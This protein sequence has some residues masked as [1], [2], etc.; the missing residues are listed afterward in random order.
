[1][2]EIQRVVR[3]AKDDA[4]GVAALLTGLTWPEVGTT[5]GAIEV[6]ARCVVRVGGTELLRSALRCD[7]LTA[8]RPGLAVALLET[9]GVVAR[10]DCGQNAARLRAQSDEVCEAALA[11]AETCGPRLARAALGTAGA[12]IGPRVDPSHLDRLC[13]LASSKYHTQKYLVMNHHHMLSSHSSSS[14][15]IIAAASDDEAQRTRAAAL[16]AIVEACAWLDESTTSFSTTM[17]T[18]MLPAPRRWLDVGKDKAVEMALRTGDWPFIDDDIY[19]GLWCRPAGPLKPCSLVDMRTQ[20]GGGLRLDLDEAGSLTAAL[21]SDDAGE[22]WIV[23]SPP[24]VKPRTWIHV[25]V[26]LR[27]LTDDEEKLHL[28]SSRSNDL[29][30]APDAP[31]PDDKTKQ[32]RPPLQ[33]RTSRTQVFFAATVKQQPQPPSRKKQRRVLELEVDGRIVATE[34]VDGIK[35]SASLR[36]ASL[37]GHFDGR[38]AGVV[39]LTQVPTAECRFSLAARCCL[40]DSDAPS[41]AADAKCARSAPYN[42]EPLDPRTPEGQDAVFACAASCLRR[43]GDAVG[44]FVFE[45]GLHKEFVSVPGE[46]AIADRGGPALLL[47]FY[48]HLCAPQAKVDLDDASRPSDSATTGEEEPLVDSVPLSPRR[49]RM[50]RWPHLRIGPR[51]ALVAAC[52]RH[53]DFCSEFFDIGGVDI[54]ERCLAVR[55]VPSVGD[56]DAA[57]IAMSLRTI[58]DAGR[59]RH[60]A[61]CVAVLRKIAFQ[62]DL[63]DDAAITDATHLW[64]QQNPRLFD[65]ALGLGV[66]LARLADL[67][68]NH[69]DFTTASSHP[70]PLVDDDDDDD[71][72]SPSGDDLVLDE[73]QDDDDSDSDDDDSDSDD[74]DDDDTSEEEEEEEDILD[75]ENG[76]KTKKAV[77]L[78][79]ADLEEEDSED[80]DDTEA[81]QRERAHKLALLPLEL[82]TTMNRRRKKEEWLRLRRARL[83]ALGDITRRL[84]ASETGTTRFRDD[85]IRFVTTH[86][87]DEAAASVVGAAIAAA[88]NDD[89]LAPFLAESIVRSRLDRGGAKSVVAVAKLWKTTKRHR[90]FADAMR[91][92][93]APITDEAYDGFLD[94]CRDEDPLLAF[95]TTA[96][97]LAA[98][99]L[100]AASARRFCDF[101]LATTPKSNVVES[102]ALDAAYIALEGYR[103]RRREDSADEEDER[104][105]D[106][107]AYELLVSSVVVGRAQETAIELATALADD[108]DAGVGPDILLRLFEDVI[109]RQG[110]A[111]KRNLVAALP[112]VAAVA[113]RPHPKDDDDRPTSPMRRHMMSPAKTSS[114]S[115]LATLPLTERRRY[116]EVDTDTDEGEAS[117]DSL[118]V[119]AHTQS[120]TF[121]ADDDDDDDEE[122]EIPP[123]EDL[124][125]AAV[126]ADVAELV[127][128]DVDEAAL[129][130]SLRVLT[131][132]VRHRSDPRDPG[133]LAALLRVALEH[134]GHHDHRHARR[135][136]LAVDA[137]HASLRAG[138]PAVES[139]FAVLVDGVRLILGAPASR[140]KPLL[141][142]ATADAL[143][144]MILDAVP[145][146]FAIVDEP[147]PPVVVVVESDDVQQRSV[148]PPTPT[149]FGTAA[150]QWLRRKRKET[151]ESPTAAMR[152]LDPADGVI[153]EKRWL[154]SPWLGDDLPAALSAVDPMARTSAWIEASTADAR[155]AAQIRAN[156]KRALATRGSAL[157]VSHDVKAPPHRVNPPIVAPTTIRRLVKRGDRCDR[158]WRAVAKLLRAEWSPWCAD[159]ASTFLRYRITKKLDRY[160][161]RPLLERDHDPRDF[162]DAAYSS[163][164]KTGTTE[165][166]V[167]PS[168]LRTA[169]AKTWSQADELR[170]R[171]RRKP[172]VLQR[173]VSAP[174]MTKTRSGSESDGV[175]GAFVVIDAA[176]PKRRIVAPEDAAKEAV[177]LETRRRW[178]PIRRFEGAVL[179]RPSGAVEG[180]LA[181]TRYAATFQGIVLRYASVERLAPRRY[182]LQHRA[183][184]WFRA[185]GTSCLF[186]LKST[187]DARDFWTAVGRLRKRGAFPIF[188]T[189]VFP[190]GHFTITDHKNKHSTSEDPMSP[191]GGAAG[192]PTTGAAAV[193]AAMEPGFATTID[194]VVA[195][196]G[197]KL[198]DAWRRRKISNFAYLAALNDMAGRTYADIS[199]WPVFPWI[200][201]DFE[202]D[203][204]TFLRPAIHQSSRRGSSVHH[205]DYYHRPSAGDVDGMDLQNLLPTD[206]VLREEEI[207]FG[208]G[209]Q[210]GLETEETALESH[211]YSTEKFEDDLLKPRY[212]DLRKPMGAHGPG[213]RVEAFEERYRSFDDPTGAVPKFMYG[214]HYS[215]AGIVLHFLVRTQPFAELAVELQGK[216][217][218]VPDRLFHSLV[219]SWKSAT[220]SMCDVKE[221]V[222]EM[223]YL[224]EV[225]INLNQLPLGSRQKPEKPPEITTPRASASSLASLALSPVANSMKA[226]HDDF[227][228][229]STSSNFMDEQHLVVNDVALP[230]WA[231]GDAYEFV[232]LHRLALEGDHVSRHLHEWIDLVFGVKQRGPRA[233]A[234]TNVFYHLTYENA[235]DVDA[236]IDDDARA[237]TLEQIKHFG[238]TPPQL[239]GTPHPPRFPPRACPTPLFAPGRALNGAPEKKSPPVAAASASS[240]FFPSASRP[241]VP[242]T[243][244]AHDATKGK[245]SVKVYKVA[246]P[247][248]LT[249][250]LPYGEQSWRRAQPAGLFSDLRRAFVAREPKLEDHEVLRRGAMLAVAIALPTTAAS[251]SSGLS[252]AP[253]KLFG[254]RTTGEKHSSVG[255]AG[256]TG[257]TTTTTTTTTT[258]A[259]GGGGGNPPQQSPETQT[260]TQTSPHHHHQGGGSPVG[261]G[262]KGGHHVHH[263]PRLVAC[264]EDRSLAAWRWSSDVPD[265]RGF[266][267]TAK[268]DPKKSN[269]R[270]QQAPRFDHRRIAAATV[271]FLRGGDLVASVGYDDG[272]LRI[273][274]TD[275]RLVARPTRGAHRGAVG[276]LAVD[277][278]DPHF[279]L[280]TGSDDGT[281]CL[282]TVGELAEALEFCDDTD[283]DGHFFFFDSNENDDDLLEDDLTFYDE[284]V[285]EAQPRRRKRRRSVRRRRSSQSSSSS[286]MLWSRGPAIVAPSRA[287]VRGRQR[288]HDM[289]VCSHK[290]WGHRS[291]IGSLAY[292]ATLDVVVSGGDDG[293]CCVHSARSGRFVRRIHRCCESRVE[294]LCL[295]DASCVF[296]AHAPETKELA[297]VTVNGARRAR[298]ALGD[299]VP[300]PPPTTSKANPEVVSRLFGSAAFANGTGAA[301]PKAAVPTTTNRLFPLR[302][303]PTATSGSQPVPRATHGGRYVSMRGTR[304]GGRIVCANVDLESIDVRVTHTLDLLQTV[305]VSAFGAPLALVFAHDDRHLLVATDDGSLLVCADPKSN[306]QQLDAALSH[307]VIGLSSLWDPF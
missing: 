166:A 185:N 63:W 301:P 247:P 129:D 226:R 141:P 233:V 30:D 10:G 116:S 190:V 291:G 3:E 71:D 266:P 179:V 157:P 178:E 304:D 292:S 29:P 34:I 206:L 75:V 279:C 282:W 28:P 240:R 25:A 164:Q 183:V 13:Q 120:A 33:R 303:E 298:I 96:T 58:L 51:L 172:E 147:P 70:P 264:Y 142:R 16:D 74:S 115:S 47:P 161:R 118:V 110:D 203:R 192:T 249:A 100:G 42:G 57:Q 228:D 14:G 123:A 209:V 200:L 217:F 61:F 48:A 289:L 263:Q 134:H 54:V 12:V 260:T 56:V 175:G 269:V 91:H 153:P 248:Q 109:P 273:H 1:M 271:A 19:V 143:V 237:A 284:E 60:M 136:L 193:Q 37:G 276:V 102:A 15:S 246:N 167:A 255:T 295:I 46:R 265:G 53:G 257:I 286:S 307:T 146:D 231:T 131:Y 89:A 180:V 39:V 306:L 274:D 232:R 210:N 43:D 294:A 9:V 220:E 181:L 268:I 201:A 125:L 36:C 20:N 215:S 191:G 259:A 253:H 195:R 221:L 122:V 158:A 252:A 222:P 275:G 52:V 7:A 280:V 119:A 198:T 50:D 67:P 177:D 41:L 199:Q 121:D 124:R 285:S 239:L 106:A 55:S 22:G 216:T 214:S 170:R 156:L 62:P 103:R 281:I 173:G 219:E 290:L 112:V 90:L 44:A 31:D 186:A 174:L 49:R 111:L 138:N 299:S 270:L 267:F 159:D 242:T 69:I 97:L 40:A 2:E 76:K 144:A 64:A 87:D 8:M 204:S 145:Q 117:M 92:S 81:Q 45:S 150:A 287:A 176:E 149:S 196:Y 4:S 184:E 296:V 234:A 137:A 108:D 5:N 197:T 227:G 11:A 101:V 235:V 256:G 83:E 135:A 88:T 165:S 59:K 224:P 133:R 152:V 244:P 297:L 207:F 251:T 21:A 72:D 218:D 160:N 223:F 6:P 140:K 139:L 278:R 148:S 300:P 18:V 194:E 151:T 17:D 68:I 65:K 254:G 168:K 35:V 78:S 127:L 107:A 211:D 114:G 84:Y 27:P 261:G 94:A 272:R 79:G 23:S 293:A 85:V 128:R 245:H 126:V 236:M 277:D 169:R 98:D 189:D 105:F 213:S 130:A 80:D 95:D 99:R 93:K 288:T 241:P 73:S 77:V 113:T 187:D 212:R 24:F 230:P 225:F 182:V 283:D 163:R 262:V 202:S 104:I 32:E 188:H 305:D 258:G 86:D 208:D 132:L 82:P 171:R 155:S 38:F 229:E 162:S 250:G 302:S 205:I 26:I 66:Y 243:S 238:Q 154:T